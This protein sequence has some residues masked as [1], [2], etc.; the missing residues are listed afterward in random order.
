MEFSI[1]THSTESAERSYSW[2]D[3]LKY[4]TNRNK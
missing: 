3:S 2:Q 1:K 4:G